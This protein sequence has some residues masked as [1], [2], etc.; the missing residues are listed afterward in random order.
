MQPIIEPDNIDTGPIR[1]YAD[2][3]SV[4]AA[5]LAIYTSAI[6]RVDLSNWNS[7]AA[8]TATNRITTLA[9]NGSA[10]STLVSVLKEG[11]AI[12]V[13]LAETLDQLQAQQQE[14]NREWGEQSNRLQE[15]AA[16]ASQSAAAKENQIRS[17]E[18]MKAV[19]ERENNNDSVRS[20]GSTIHS[21]KAELSTLQAQARNA[22][23]AIEE[24]YS[25]YVTNMQQ[26]K[27]AVKD[28]FRQASHALFSL[29]GVDGDFQGDYPHPEMSVGAAFA[30]LPPTRTLADG[31]P[32]WKQYEFYVGGEEQTDADRELF[33]KLVQE[34]TVEGVDPIWLLA[35]A[36]MNGWTW[37]G[38]LSTNVLQERGEIQDARWTNE[39][40]VAAAAGIAGYLNWAATNP[41]GKTQEQFEASLPQETRD[42]LQALR[43]V[44]AE[45]AEAIAQ[46][47][48]VTTQTQ[49]YQWPDG[50]NPSPAHREAMRLLENNSMV[51]ALNE[52]GIEGSNLHDTLVRMLH[53]SGAPVPPHNSTIF[54]RWS[55]MDLSAPG[56]VQRSR[57]MLITHYESDVGR[58]INEAEREVLTSLTENTDMS[59]DMMSRL[60]DVA[61]VTASTGY[62]DLHAEGDQPQLRFGGV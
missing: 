60:H 41:A 5:Q 28:A 14:V 4:A 31:E 55:T 1:A 38:V 30:V 33:Q 16:N 26:K 62:H 15:D 45:N 50:T 35:V 2:N 27:E 39:A 10:G 29:R 9:A 7:A 8:Q 22:T 42:T 54:E 18:D 44:T 23:A 43:G 59:R 47:R 52:V 57:G 34:E 3:Y 53:N 20:L 40:G 13:R 46:Q 11:R 37:S 36:Q 58:P 24:G 25:N 12:L 49:G 17:F 56:S 51:E 21:A 19:Q 32:E 61:Q 6:A 48:S